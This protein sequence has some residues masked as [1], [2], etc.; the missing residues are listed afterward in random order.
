MISIIDA[1]IIAAVLL[2]S[3]K[4]AGIKIKDEGDTLL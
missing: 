3:L 2:I 1:A 4:L